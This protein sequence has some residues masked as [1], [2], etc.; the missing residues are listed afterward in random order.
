MR[1][2]VIILFLL[3]GASSYGQFRPGLGGVR[4]EDPRSA[5]TV[6]TDNSGGFLSGLFDP[7]R[8]S[9]HQTYSMSFS[10]SGNASVG[11]GVFTNTFSYRA[12]DNLF[13]SADLS[14]VYSPYSSL[15]EQHAK[16]LN[17]IYLSNARLDWKLG[18]HTNLLIIYN[19]GS[20]TTNPFGMGSY[21]PGLW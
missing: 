14:A 17:G 7:T 15:G 21:Y 8:F 16:I 2:S 13:I 4:D 20:P 5:K 10:S 3:I 11:L 6:M 18:E 1:T 19:G 9:M 12:A